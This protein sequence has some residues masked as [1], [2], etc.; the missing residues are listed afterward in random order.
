M[1]QMVLEL[2]KQVDNLQKEIHMFRSLGCSLVRP[3]PIMNARITNLENSNKSHQNEEEYDG[4]LTSP[5][6][7]EIHNFTLPLEHKAPKFK[8]FSGE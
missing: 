3:E 6:S 4:V 1:E 2:H 5:L 7:K 8:I